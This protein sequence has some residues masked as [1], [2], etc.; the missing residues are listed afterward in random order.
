MSGERRG[1]KRVRFDRG[2]AASLMAIDGTWRRE[3]TVV[4][5]S[6][7]GAQLSAANVGGLQLT[8][9]FL[10]LTAVGVAYRRCQLTWVNGETIGVTFISHGRGKRTA[11]KSRAEQFV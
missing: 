11:Q 4:D 2:L 3:C 5:I 9:F 10:L 1:G 7:E 8:E 6:D